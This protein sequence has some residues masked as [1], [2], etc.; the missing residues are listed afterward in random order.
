MPKLEL[1]DTTL[2]DGAQTWGITF[3]LD[4]KIRIALKLD[5]LG[6]DLIEGGY[7]GSNP[8]DRKFFT[9]AKECPLNMPGLRRLEVIVQ[10]RYDS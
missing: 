1:Y 10:A 8:K 2:R 7:P 4:D 3:S 6:I 9:T 5:E